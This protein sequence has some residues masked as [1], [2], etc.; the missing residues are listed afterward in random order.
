MYNV[1]YLLWLSQ[2]FN[3]S[4]LS[5]EIG[6]HVSMSRLGMCKR[7]VLLKIVSN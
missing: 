2:G 5:K 4:W 6:L 7:P 3:L 1:M